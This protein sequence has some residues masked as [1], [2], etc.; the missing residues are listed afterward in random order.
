MGKLLPEA[1]HGKDLSSQDR[2]CED[3]ERLSDTLMIFLLQSGLSTF[4][5]STRLDREAALKSIDRVEKTLIASIA[6][7][8]SDTVRFVVGQTGQLY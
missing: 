5:R 1:P 6:T 7:G 3:D 2:L 8:H 4:R